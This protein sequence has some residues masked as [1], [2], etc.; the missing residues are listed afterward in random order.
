MG[1]ESNINNRHNPYLLFVLD[2]VGAFA[3][4]VFGMD[5]LRGGIPIISPRLNGALFTTYYRIKN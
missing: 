4:Y 2:D 1:D 3:K 5:K